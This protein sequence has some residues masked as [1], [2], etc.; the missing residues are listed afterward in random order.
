MKENTVFY[1]IMGILALGLVLS[2][3]L[4]FKRSKQLKKFL[5]KAA[6]NENIVVVVR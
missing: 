2:L 4:D 3:Y 5:K 6:K 1:T